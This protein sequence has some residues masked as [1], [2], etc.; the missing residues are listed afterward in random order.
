MPWPSP[1]M[2]KDGVKAT[3]SFP[4][5]M[6]AREMVKAPVP[7]R[8]DVFLNP[9][10]SFSEKTKARV[11]TR[12]ERKKRSPIW[13]AVKFRLVAYTGKRVLTIPVM[14]E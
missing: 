2:A 8:K 6:R 7:I 1:K 10:I 4:N 12:F 14:K 11:W 9:W 13:K 3:A 5:T